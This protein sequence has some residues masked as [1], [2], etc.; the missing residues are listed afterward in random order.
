[1]ETIFVRGMSC[2]HCRESVVEALSRVPGV[3]KVE[4]SLKEALTRLEVG[5]GY[6]RQ[7]AQRAIELI[8]FEAGEP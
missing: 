1:M 6:D 3:V 7:A 2:E 4:V 8:G 5:P